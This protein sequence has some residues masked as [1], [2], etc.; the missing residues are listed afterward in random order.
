MNN[1][2][3]NVA[4]LRNGGNVQRTSSRIVQNTKLN[5]EDDD[6]FK[7]V[8]DEDGGIM[9]ADTNMTDTQNN[10]A[11]PSIVQ[12]KIGKILQKLQFI[13]T[14]RDSLNNA[15]HNNNDNVFANDASAK[16][17]NDDNKNTN[18]TSDIN[19]KIVNG[20]R[21]KIVTDDNNSSTDFDELERELDDVNID[22]DVSDSKAKS[23]SNFNVTS[24]GLFLAELVGTAV[25]LVL[26][27]AAQFT[28]GQKN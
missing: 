14:I 7:E 20:K 12:K 22:D 11:L 16:I 1:K 8:D 4:N 9:Y 10:E 24:I 13:S 2:S 27:A 28:N 6:F 19:A 25:G 15:G 26:G 3:S 17:I 23:S 21:A 5:D 18:K